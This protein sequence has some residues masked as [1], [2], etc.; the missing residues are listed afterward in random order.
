MHFE[1]KTP[2]FHNTIENNAF[3]IVIRQKTWQ[4]QSY[5]PKFENLSKISA[6]L[7]FGADLEVKMWSRIFVLQTRPKDILSPQHTKFLGAEIK[8]LTLAHS[9][10]EKSDAAR[11]NLGHS[12]FAN[13]HKR[14]VSPSTF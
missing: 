1:E 3:H 5:F 11:I 10:R 13:N 12:S 2:Y 6:S 7:T 14:Y 9:K 8:I 4:T